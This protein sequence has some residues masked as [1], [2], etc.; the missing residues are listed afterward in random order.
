[1][2]LKR[3]WG[4]LDTG[5]GVQN[6]DVLPAAAMDGFTAARRVSRGLQILCGSAR[7]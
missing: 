3:S 4:P 7:S 5:R 2:M 1:M 6:R